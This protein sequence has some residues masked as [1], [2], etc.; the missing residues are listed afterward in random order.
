MS[1]PGLSVVKCGI[2]PECSV[3]EVQYSLEQPQVRKPKLGAEKQNHA[4]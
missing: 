3:H 1:H 2:Y 4:F